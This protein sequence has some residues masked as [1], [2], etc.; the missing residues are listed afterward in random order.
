MTNADRLIVVRTVVLL[1]IARAL[2][3]RRG[4]ARTRAVLSRTPLGGRLDV[5]PARTSELVTR[6]VGIAGGDATCLQRSLVLLRLLEQAGCP[7]QLQIGV[8]R[9]EGASEFHA[10]VTLDGTVLNDSPEEVATYTTFDPSK[11]PLR[12]IR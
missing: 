2:L 1:A 9:G 5:Q 11:L 10:W 7:G 6:V 12:T 8:R 4:L 3:P